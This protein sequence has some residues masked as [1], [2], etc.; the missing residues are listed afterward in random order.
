MHEALLRYPEIISRTGFSRATLERMVAGG[1]FPP[2]RQIGIKAVAWLQSE[3][4]AWMRDRPVVVY[5]AG[6]SSKSGQEI[7]NNINT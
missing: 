4:E 2:P 6:I 7:A 5:K 3:V 1:T